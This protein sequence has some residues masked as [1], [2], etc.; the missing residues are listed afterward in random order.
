MNEEDVP[1]N[2]K[3]MKILSPVGITSGIKSTIKFAL[4]GEMSSD[5]DNNLRV[6]LDHAIEKVI[7]KNESSD[8]I[9]IE[10]V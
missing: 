1:E 9:N 6:H 10:F 3:L 2:Q 7:T 8:K 4:V 5:P